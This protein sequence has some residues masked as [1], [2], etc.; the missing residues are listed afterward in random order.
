MI[1]SKCGNEINDNMQ[2]CVK[3]GTP[4]DLEVKSSMVQPPRPIIPQAGPQAPKPGVTQNPRP[5]MPQGG[6]Q[7]PRSGMPQAPR[8]GMPQAGPQAPRPGMPQ[9]PR[10]GM[11]QA[12]PQAPRPGMPEGQNP[13]NETKGFFTNTVRRV[14]N[15]MTGGAVDREISRQAVNDYRRN[16]QDQI[17]EQQQQLNE[18]QAAVRNEQRQLDREVRNRERSRA[19]YNLDLIDGVEVVRGHAIWD[20]QPGEIARRIKESELEEIEK[21]KGIIVQEGCSAIIFANGELIANLSAGAYSFLKS[22]EEEAEALKKAEE[23]AIRRLQEVIDKENKIR[24]VVKPT[25]RELGIVGEIGRGI[26]WFGRLIFGEKKNGPK[27]DSKKRQQIFD[28]LLSQAKKENRP[29]V[30]SVYIVSNRFIPMTF[31]GVQDQEGNINFEPFKVAVGIQDVEIGVSLQMRVSDIHQLVTNYL[32]D[33]TSLTTTMLFATMNPIIGNEVAM[34]LRNIDYQATGLPLDIIENLKQEITQ[35]LNSTVHGLTCE[36]VVSIT[37]KSQDFERFRN[38][39]RQLYNSEKEL[40]YMHRTGEFRNRM[41][42]E[43]NSQA[44]NSARNAEDLRHSMLL[45]NKDQL[46]NDAELE[47]FVYLFESERRIKHATTDEEEYAA[48]QDLKKNRL[49]K[50]DDVEQLIDDIAHKKIPRDEITQIMRVNSQMNVDKAILAAEWAIDDSREDHDWMREDLAR[51][52]NW[53]IEDEEMEREWARE[54][55][56]YDRAIGRQREEDEYDFKLMMRRREIEREDHMLARSEHL[57]DRAL[58]RSE[59][60]E[61]ERLAY[62]RERQRMFDEDSLEGNRHQRSIDK[63]QAMAEMQAKLEAQQQQH[64]QNLASIEANERMNRDNIFSQM[65]AEQIRAA[66]LSHLSAEAQVAMANSYGSDKENEVLRA[67]QADKDQM[68]QQMLKMQQEGQAAQMAAMMQMAG[69]I[70]DT[71]SNVS[72]AVNSATQQQNER[73]QASLDHQQERMDHLQDVSI[74]TLGTVSNSAASNIGA[75]NGGAFQH[76]A[77]QTQFAQQTSGLQSRQI[78]QASSTSQDTVGAEIIEFQCYNCGQ[79]VQAPYGASNCP[80]CGAPFQW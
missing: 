51:R 60:L 49:L 65:N 53:G 77:A 44:L 34:R 18:L 22:A 27:E 45:L 42:I 6:P 24:Q 66:Q 10:P 1:C 69:M 37:D 46:L 23:K 11:P 59:K 70:K 29:P 4:I 3:C 12:G 52:R 76:Q 26:K 67:A 72:G 28:N 30:L 35:K 17:Q 48:L 50:D 74:Q 13:N 41:E 2:F 62:E 56:E 61:D 31:S 55:R 20:I 64:Q 39:E 79:T 25:F 38:I 8:P 63:L 14:A 58:D 7:A 47:D 73:L 9:P 43:A 21:I 68:Y 32:S 54:Q 78:P 40:D 80:H 71:A 19:Q 33:H 16:N 75:Y 36:Q 15:A 5:G 57:E